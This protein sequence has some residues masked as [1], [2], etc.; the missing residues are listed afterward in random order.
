MR[1]ETSTLHPRPVADILSSEL[2]WFA[3]AVRSRHEFV[4]RDELAGKGVETFLP[5][6]MK[7]QQWRDRR[8]QV[9]FAVFPGYCFVHIRPRA[10]EFLHVLKTR[11]TVTL[12]SLVPGHPTPVPQDEIDALR[13]VTVSGEPFDVYPGYKLGRRV[14][15]RRGPLRGA[16]GVLGTRDSHQMFFVNI[17]ILGRSVGLR[18]AADD[19]EL[20]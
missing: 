8:K 1:V 14:R 12:V 15:I 9:E 5:T 4:A 6:V 2:S 20:V 7:L 18:M 13:T 3:L 11:G 16:E 17:E 19:M 10:D